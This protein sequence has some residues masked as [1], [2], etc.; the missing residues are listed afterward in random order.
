MRN[1]APLSE[2]GFLMLL[3]IMGDNTRGSG[4]WDTPREGICHTPSEMELSGL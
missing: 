1:L 3:L 4:L 2:R